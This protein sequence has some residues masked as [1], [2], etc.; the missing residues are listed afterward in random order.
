MSYTASRTWVSNGA[1]ERDNFAKFHDNCIHV[2]PNS[3]FVPK[4]L[5]EWIV[6]RMW[7]IGKGQQNSMRRLDYKVAE[8]DMR[9]EGRVVEPAFAGKKFDDYLSP[10]LSMPSIWVC[11]PP[12]REQAPWPGYDEFKHEGHRRSKSGHCRFPPL[13]RVPGNVTVSWKQR[14]LII[15]YPFDQVGHSTLAGKE[16]AGDE[17]V[18]DSDE[19]A[20]LIG[21][22]LL[23][24]LGD[25]TVG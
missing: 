16:G 1:K 4:T 12:G 17:T 19:M 23:K 3:P 7:V 5:Q 25:K 9:K 21:N 10:V 15:P 18:N 11:N 20:F 2:A 14:A 13:P 8:R 24:E 22:D 6:H